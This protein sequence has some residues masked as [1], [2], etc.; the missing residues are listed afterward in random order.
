[1]AYDQ[2]NQYSGHIE[3]NY[4]YHFKPGWAFQTKLYVIGMETNFDD[5]F[6]DRHGH[7][8]VWDAMFGAGVGI[9]YYFNKREWDRCNS[10]PQDIIYINKKINQIRADCP[11]TETGI[12]E[13]YVFYPNNYF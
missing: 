3:V 9:S 2:S 4:E 6:S 13:F 11:K 1:M 12:L 7:A 8:D 5:V 10:C